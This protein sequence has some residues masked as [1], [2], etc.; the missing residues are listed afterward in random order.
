MNTIKGGH[1]FKFILSGN[2]PVIE[3]DGIPLEGVRNF[4]VTASATDVSRVVLVMYPHS[5]EFDGEVQVDN[6][7]KSKP[8]QCQKW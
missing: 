5:V 4:V 6:K 8:L 2:K 3:M 1:N 7:A